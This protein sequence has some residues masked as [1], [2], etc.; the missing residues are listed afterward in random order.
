MAYHSLSPVP[1]SAKSFGL[2][3]LPGI[4]LAGCMSGAERQQVNLDNDATT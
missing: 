4:G 3:A 2:V 1:R